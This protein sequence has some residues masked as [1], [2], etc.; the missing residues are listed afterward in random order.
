MN[1]DSATFEKLWTQLPQT[2]RRGWLIAAYARYFAFIELWS[3]KPAGTTIEL[4]GRSVDGLDAFFCAIGEAVNGPAG[5]FGKNLNGFAD[6]VMGG[7]GITPP[8]ILRWHY[9]DMARIALGVQETLR[10]AREQVELDDFPDDEARKAAQ[11]MIEDLSN[12][13]SLTLFDMIIEILNDRNV[14]VE[15][16]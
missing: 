10:Y 1:I 16:L 14:T 4:D 3:Q 5:Y 15:L 11:A 2:A 6:C 13:Q 7:F 12:D 9:S 8:W